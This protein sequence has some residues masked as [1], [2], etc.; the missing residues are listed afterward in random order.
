MK[1]NY[2]ISTAAVLAALLTVSCT[3]DLQENTPVSGKDSAKVTLLIAADEVTKTTFGD[4][5]EVKWEN[6]DKIGI[7]IA[8]SSTNVQASLTRDGAGKAYFAA[9]VSN[10]NAGDQLCAYYP[11]AANPKAD[12]SKVTLK[13]P[14][15]QTQAAPDKFDGSNNPM[16]AVPINLP[17]LEK[18]ADG[19]V[20]IPEQ[21]KF[22]HIGAVLEFDITGVPADEKL[23][24]VQFVSSDGTPAGDITYKITEVSEKDMPEPTVSDN[25]SGITVTLSSSEVAGDA[26]VYMV[27]FPGTYTGEIVITTDRGGYNYSV[28]NIHAERA[29]VKTIKVDLSKKTAV[30]NEIKSAEDYEAFVKVVNAGEDYSSW[31]DASGEVKL[32][33]DISTTNNFT[34]ITKEWNGVF[35][36]NGHT[37][38]QVNT[39]VPLFTIVGKDGVVKNLNLEGNLKKAS[40]PSGPSTA[41]V[42]QINR[43]TIKNVTNSIDINLTNVDVAYMIGGMVIM[44][45]GLMEGC[46]QV[47]NITVDYNVTKPITVKVNNK[48]VAKYRVVTYIGGVACFAADAAEYATDESKV[49]V[50]TFRNCAN[51]GN[52][53]INKTGVANSYLGK[54]AMGGICAIVQ[55]GTAEAHPL[56]EGCRN[57]GKIVRKDASNGLNACSAIGGIVGRASSY[58]KLSDDSAFDVDNYNVYL[59]ISDC[60]NTGDIECSAFLT[61]GWA[62]GSSTS[63][64]RM[65]ATGGIIGYVNGFAEVPAIITD[66][67]STCTISG[68]HSNQSVLLGGI[69]GM[70]SRTTIENCAAVT[71]FVDSS[72]GL[73]NQKVA[74]VGGVIGYVRHDS[75]ITGGQYSA[76]IAM[77]ETTVADIG[78]CAGGSYVGKTP[79]ILT[80]TNAKFCGS[81]AHKGL[82]TPVTVTAENLGDNLVSFGKCNKEGGITYWTK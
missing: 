20:V 50:G 64:A 66:C 82:E 43:G 58:Y 6:D 68:G 8:S 57:E 23:K 56:F 35:N 67:T 21:L 22:R 80:V 61:N 5:F 59:K 1:V 44:N 47:G 4:N 60:H 40:Y 19:T 13:V 9:K 15:I 29:V 79:Q 71:N 77:P 39:T 52:I 48:D 42:A 73:D 76:V 24:S 63:G 32:R 30:K 33:A 27:L 38:T 49:N 54:F 34:R 65:G 18:T 46:T 78:I 25:H 53:T 36:G 14:Y 45:G 17:S 74:V 62:L 28:Q 55:N 3:K 10:Y 11:Y 69:A 51:Y 16:I 75:A 26:K 81:I 41:A 7:F 31:K 70:T 37:M 12:A 72:L 2:M